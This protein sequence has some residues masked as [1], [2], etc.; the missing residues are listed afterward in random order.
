VQIYRGKVHELEEVLYRR[1]QQDEQKLISLSN[2]NEML[3][4]RLE[5]EQ[6]R[7]TEEGDS[8]LPLSVSFVE[9]RRNLFLTKRKRRG[10]FQLSQ[11]FK[12]RKESS[13]AAAIIRMKRFLERGKS[14]DTRQPLSPI[15]TRYYRQST[16][17]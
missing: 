12:Q 9:S 2:H 11:T 6:R 5:L 1:Q 10:N 14:T 3:E 16:D 15:R 13:T 17:R 7:R 8:P 4:T